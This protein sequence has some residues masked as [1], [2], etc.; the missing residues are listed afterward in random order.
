[1]VAQLQAIVPRTWAAA[2]LVDLNE[3]QRGDTSLFGSERKPM[4][5][6]ES[7][8]AVID[9]SCK[10]LVPRVWR[11]HPEQVG[12]RIVG[13]FRCQPSCCCLKVLLRVLVLLRE[14]KMPMQCSLRRGGS[15]EMRLHHSTTM[16]GLRMLQEADLST[17]ADELRTDEAPLYSYRKGCVGSSPWRYT[18]RLGTVYVG[19]HVPYSTVGW[20]TERDES[21]EAGRCDVGGPLLCL[22]S[23]S[24]LLLDRCVCLC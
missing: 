24:S 20:R 23:V 8:E 15:S 11:I 18:A 2:N 14:R 21:G 6:G 17:R 1:M 16:H 4:E 5:L 7:C 3:H 13:D 19:V 12:I 9:D 22:L 10:R